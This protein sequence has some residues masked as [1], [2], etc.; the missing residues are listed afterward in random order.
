[1][2]KSNSILDS[3]LSCFEQNFSGFY[4][5]FKDSFKPRSLFL[6][7]QICHSVNLVQ[8]RFVRIPV[9]RYILGKVLVK[10]PQMPSLKG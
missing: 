8:K 7:K 1:M 2:K 3:Q 9:Q 4:F 6:V 5:P 10:Q